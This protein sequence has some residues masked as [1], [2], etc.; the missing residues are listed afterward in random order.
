MTYDFDFF[1]IG[2]GSGGVRAARTASGFGA[3]VAVAEES[4]LGGTCVNRGCVPKKMF[5]YAS[6]FRSDFVDAQRFGWASEVPS[7]DWLTLRNNK[8]SEI[9]RL[10]QIYGNLLE[11]ANVSLIQG[12]AKIK[13]PNEVQVGEK[14]YTADKIL[15]TVGGRPV[16]PSFEG[17]EFA[18][19][20]DEAFHLEKLPK[21]AVVLGGGYIAVEF[22]GIFA[23]LGVETTLLHR[24]DRVL[25]GFDEDVRTHLTEELPKHHV[26]LCMEKSVSRIEKTATGFKVHTLEGTTIEAEMVM[27]DLVVLHIQRHLASKT[28][29]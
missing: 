20:S 13:G 22:A 25:R 3:K 11:K 15:I 27:T 4:T 10:N 6:H 2:A 8:D 12:Y 7:F 23:G 28:L 5:S 26:N 16:T 17:G 1:V 14:I 29:V 21:S 9:A 19:T 24:R 18:V